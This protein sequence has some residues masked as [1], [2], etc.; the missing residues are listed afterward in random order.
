MQA[1]APYPVGYSHSP[2]RFPCVF[3]DS[4]F[5]LCGNLVQAAI[6]RGSTGPVRVCVVEGVACLCERGVL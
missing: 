1:L 5:V 3:V 4:S 6:H 2:C